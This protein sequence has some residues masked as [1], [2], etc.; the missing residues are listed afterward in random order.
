ML[1]FGASCA[2]LVTG[3]VADAPCGDSVEGA[4]SPCPGCVGSEGTDFLG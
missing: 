4:R 1:S 2:V 3:V